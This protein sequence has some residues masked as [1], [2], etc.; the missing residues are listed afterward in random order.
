MNDSNFAD[1]ASN[2]LQC[3]NRFIEFLHLPKSLEKARNHS[4]TNSDYLFKIL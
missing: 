4:S 1:A 3:E 2:K